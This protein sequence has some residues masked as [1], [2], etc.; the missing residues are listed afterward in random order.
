MAVNQVPPEKGIYGWL[1]SPGSLPAPDA[2]YACTGGFELL[3]IGIA[4]REPST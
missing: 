2:P 3:C 1:F 4:P